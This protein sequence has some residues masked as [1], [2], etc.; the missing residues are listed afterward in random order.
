MLFHI[1]LN[2]TVTVCL[3]T[4]AAAVTQNAGQLLRNCCEGISDCL[5][6][7]NTFDDKIPDRT[8]ADIPDRTAADIPSVQS[9]SSFCMNAIFIL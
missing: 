6:L 1:Y 4:S 3:V 5:C 2:I 9:A 8:A 7:G